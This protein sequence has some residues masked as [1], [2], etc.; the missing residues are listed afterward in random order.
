V[1]VSEYQQARQTARQAGRQAGRPPPI[2]LTTEATL[3]LLQK[4]LKGMVKEISSF[5]T[6][7]MEQELLLRKR[8]IFQQ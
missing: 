2:V 3:I 8:P 4:Q 6:L 7:E 1:N 5:L